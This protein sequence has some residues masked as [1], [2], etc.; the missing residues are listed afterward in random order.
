MLLL[1]YN[2]DFAHKKHPPVSQRT[3]ANHKSKFTMLKQFF[4]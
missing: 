4:P 2:E 3:D 1:F